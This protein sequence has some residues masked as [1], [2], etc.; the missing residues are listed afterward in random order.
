M[1]Y[2]VEWEWFDFCSGCAKTKVRP[3]SKGELNRA[4]I[5]KHTFAMHCVDI[6]NTKAGAERFATMITNYECYGN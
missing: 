2:A 4:W 3:A 1:R 5:D 6:F